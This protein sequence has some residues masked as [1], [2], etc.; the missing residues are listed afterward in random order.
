MERNPSPVAVEL[1]TDWFQNPIDGTRHRIFITNVL[2][3]LSEWYPASHQITAP[4]Q[5]ETDRKQETRPPSLR[6]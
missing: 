4:E 6:F 5:I 2:G 3:A 1:P